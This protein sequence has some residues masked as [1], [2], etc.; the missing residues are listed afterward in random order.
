MSMADKSL[1]LVDE[2]CALHNKQDLHFANHIG[3]VWIKCVYVAGIAEMHTLLKK[4]KN[5]TLTML[6]VWKQ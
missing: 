2:Q 3:N 4:G 1:D 5:Q 6:G